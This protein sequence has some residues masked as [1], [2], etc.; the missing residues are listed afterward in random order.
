MELTPG[1]PARLPW[2]DPASRLPQPPGVPL[3][4]LTYVV[5]DV[6]TTGMRADGGDRITEIAA[7]VMEGGVV[8]QRFETLINP[9]RSIPPM[10]T[11]LTRITPAMVRH[12]P[13]F[14]EVAGEVARLMHGRVFVAHNADFDWR[15]VCAEMARATG[16]VPANER[17]CTVRLARRM[18]PH[19][20]SRRLNALAHYYGIEIAER[21]RAGGDAAATARIL[22]RLLEHAAEQACASWDDLQR[23]LASRRPRRRRSALPT[24]VDRDTT[25]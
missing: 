4:H 11:A 22:L 6:E 15:F 1:R 20:R 14:A 3:S 5:V 19:L 18:L 9:Q 24:S 13:P 8:R 16:R 23:L 17:L 12:A 21:H 25:A 10:I 2:D 7:L